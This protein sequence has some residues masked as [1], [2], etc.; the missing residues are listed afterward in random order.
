MG[1]TTP[2]ANRLE[3]I[4]DTPH[5]FVGSL[6]NVDHKTLGKRYLVTAF[7]FL[8][9][10]GIEAAL[11]RAQ[12]ARPGQHLLSAEA[13]NQLFTMHGTT[14]MF[15]YAAPV[16]SGFSNYSCSRESFSTPVFWLVPRQTVDGSTT[17]R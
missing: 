3:K 5:T 13:Y 17:Y 16:L 9:L 14:M 7:I 4:W 12:L 11:M 1:T 2:L 6:T 8:C 10:G 15:L